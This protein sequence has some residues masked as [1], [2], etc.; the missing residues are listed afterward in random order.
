[1]SCGSSQGFREPRIRLR[2]RI[3]TREATGIDIDLAPP[4][5]EY[6]R[7]SHPGVSGKPEQRVMAQSGTLLEKAAELVRGPDAMGAISVTSVLRGVGESCGILPQQV[8]A[9]CVSESGSQ[10][11]VDLVHSLR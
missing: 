4:Q 6:L 11:H 7:T 8:F 9:Y 3:D 1:M 5:A 2:P 10:D